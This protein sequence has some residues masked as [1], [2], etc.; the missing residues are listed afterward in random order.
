MDGLN[1]L[2]LMLFSLLGASLASWMIYEFDNYGQRYTS[3]LKRLSERSKCDY[4]QEQVS[5]S[6]LVPV[7]SYIF[8]GGKT[9]CCST[10]LSKK[11]IIFESFGALIFAVGYLIN[12]LE[13]SILG[14]LIIFIIFNDEKYK[15]IP[16]WINLALFSWVIIFGDE[17]IEN[18][19]LPALYLAFALILLYLFFLKV[20]RVEGLGLA[21]IILLFSISLYLGF[22][23]FLYLITIASA[24]LLIKIILTKKLRE[25]HAFGSWIA[26]AF[27]AFILFQ[28]F[29]VS[30]N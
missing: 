23:D 6:N 3:V 5:Y 14:F 15:E 22:P 30:A 20:R 26:G 21:D 13:I 28:E 16:I 12:T 18:N 1:L 2:H 11:Y 4:C 19:F 7:L 29:Y 8:L 25:P 17:L 24:S 27:G 9:S 10:K